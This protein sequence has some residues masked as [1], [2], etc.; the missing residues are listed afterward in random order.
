[1][2]R[3]AAPLIAL[4]VLALVAAPAEAAVGI[5]KTSRKAG[6]P[7]D[8]VTVTLGCGFCYPPC[9]GPRGQRQP[10]PCMLG[11]EGRRPPASFG[12]SLVPVEKL[13]VPHPCGP[14]ALC[15]PEASA[16]P[17]RAPFRYLGEA[18]A[19]NDITQKT[20]R[21]PV[22]RYRLDFTVPDLRPGTYTYVIYCDVCAKGAGGSLIAGGLDP[23]HLPRRYLLEVRAPRGGASIGS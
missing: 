4:A 7:G 22:P 1:M 21:V 18:A 9:K 19:L 8:T 15:A 3:I 20:G 10:K 17:R 23:D 16:P 6:A 13:P 14:K 5:E 11:T 12:I 2:H